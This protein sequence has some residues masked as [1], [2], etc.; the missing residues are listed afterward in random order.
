MCFYV[1]FYLPEQNIIVEVE[2]PS[3]FLAPTRE[4][5]GT[6]E[7]RYRVIERAHKGVKIVKLP[8]FLNERGEKRIE[9]IIEEEIIN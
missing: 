4:R 6:L 8:Y 1:D 7:A 2:G 5:N 9:E 3:H